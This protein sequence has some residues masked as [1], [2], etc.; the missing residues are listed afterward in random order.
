MCAA[1]EEARWDNLGVGMVGDVVSSR[2][3]DFAVFRHWTCSGVNE[4]ELMRRCVVWD[5]IIW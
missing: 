5:A 4:G 1:P 2:P 3:K